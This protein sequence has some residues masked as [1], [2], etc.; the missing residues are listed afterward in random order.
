MHYS[1]LTKGLCHQLVSSTCVINLYALVLGTLFGPTVCSFPYGCHQLVSQLSRYTCS[2]QPVS[3][4][5]ASKG[6][7]PGHGVPQR[8]QESK[9]RQTHGEHQPRL[10]NLHSNDHCEA[11]LSAI[12]RNILPLPSGQ[13]SG[14]EQV[15]YVRSKYLCSF[16]STGSA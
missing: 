15:L 7:A 11:V 14:T 1:T 3:E 5:A 2:G 10:S 9:Q 12:K 4:G 6:E 13:A 8:H 16:T